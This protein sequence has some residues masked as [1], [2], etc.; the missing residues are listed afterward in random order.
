ML[1]VASRLIATEEAPQDIIKLNL[2]IDV[3]LFELIEVNQHFV[4]VFER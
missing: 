4:E 2:G 1:V 3:L